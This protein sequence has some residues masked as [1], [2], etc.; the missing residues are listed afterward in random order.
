MATDSA[1]T[2]LSVAIA[3]KHL[4]TP[5]SQHC[6]YYY[7]PNTNT[8]SGVMLLSAPSLS[9]RCARFLCHSAVLLFA[10][11]T[12]LLFIIIIIIIIVFVIIYFYCYYCFCHG[13]CHCHCQ[14]HCH[15]HFHCYCDCRCRCQCQCYCYNVLSVSKIFN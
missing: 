10:I 4:C 6:H 3:V 9:Q 5:L 7:C 14:C 1:V 13:Y 8:V 2:A 15:C 12:L 11:T